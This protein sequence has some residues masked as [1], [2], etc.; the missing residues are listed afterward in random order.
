MSKLCRRFF[1]R[2]TLL[3]ARE[4]VGKKLVHH[5]TKGDIVGMVTETE[6]YCGI[7]D[8]ASHAYNGKV[9]T[10]NKVMYGDGGFA[11]IYLIYGMYC[12]LN[13]V[14]EKVGIPGSVF[15]RAVKPVEGIEL[16]FKNRELESKFVGSNIYKLTNGPCKLCQ[17]FGIT[18]QMNGINICGD[19]LYILDAPKVNNKFIKTTP[20]VGIDCAGESK[21]YPWRFVVVK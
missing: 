13:I 5:T 10:R 17:A 4:L 12:C 16:M 2:N 6:A 19:K 11:Y 15:I 18:K 20:R 7:N 1:E 8:R 21:H 9:T 14:T 3:V